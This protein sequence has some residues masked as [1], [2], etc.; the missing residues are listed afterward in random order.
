LKRVAIQFIGIITLLI[1]IITSFLPMIP[2]GFILNIIGVALLAST[3]RRLTNIVRTARKNHPKI[4]EKIVSIE[5]YTPIYIRKIL[6][7]LRPK[8][9]NINETPHYNK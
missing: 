1:G 8:G 4:D 7:K 9:K 2:T 3:S 6:V 5:K